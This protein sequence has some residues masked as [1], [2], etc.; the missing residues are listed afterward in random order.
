MNTY[1]IKIE[2]YNGV[3]HTACGSSGTV[4]LDGRYSLYNLLESVPASF[5][6]FVIVRAH[7]IGSFGTVVY[8]NTGLSNSQINK[9][10]F[11]GCYK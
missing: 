6:L 2:N 8:H 5:D 9:I 4:R 7:S 1:A 3:Y 10:A 11:E